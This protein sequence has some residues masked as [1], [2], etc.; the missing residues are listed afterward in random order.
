MN[1]A[2]KL[3]I[4][5]T[6]I[7][8]ILTG[9]GW[10][11]SAPVTSL[12]ESGEINMENNLGI[13]D[14]TANDIVSQMKVGWNLGN[15]MDV[16]ESTYLKTMKPEKW[17][18]GWG[19]PVTTEALMQK[20]I[21]SGFNVIR[22]PVSWND[23]IFVG[24]GYKIEEGWMD[25]IQEI[26]DY[27]Y[28]QDAYV[29]L[30]THHESWYYP[31]YDNKEH[32]SEMMEAIWNQIAERFQDYGEKLIFEGMNEPRKI[33]TDMEWN[34]GDQEGWDMVNHFN[35]VFIETIRNA[36][37]NNPDRILMIPGY[38]ANC[39][40]AIEHIEVPEDTKIIVSV[41]AYEPYDFAL[42]TKGRNTWNRDT[43]NIDNLLK[44]IDEKFISK[45]IPVIIGEFGAMY[46][47][48]EGNEEDRAAWAN[49]YV[50][51]A[52]ELGIPCVWWDNGAFEGDGELFGLINRETCEWKYPL[53]IKGLMEGTGQT[54]DMSLLEQN[55]PDE[56]G[57]FKELISYEDGIANVGNLYRLKSAMQKAQAG[58]D[59]TVAFIG[60][61]ITQGSLSSKPTTCYAYLVYEW[62]Q[63]KF[64]D[65][66]I[67]YVNAGIGGTTS[68]FGV[69]RVESD[70]LGFEP[71]VTFVEFSV[72]DENNAFY[73][74]T[75]EG[76][77]RKI[78]GSDTD[79]AVMLLHNVMY[80]NGGNAQ[81]QHEQ[82][83][84]HYELPCLS[85]KTSVYSK[86][87][88]GTIKNREITPDDLHPNDKG[89]DL[90]AGLVISF[91]EEV[92]TDLESEET[93]VSW[94]KDGLPEALTVNAYENSIR[95]QNGN[96]SPVMNGFVA[97]TQEQKHIT[98][99]FRNGWTAEKVGDSIEFEVE[100]TGIAVQY[101]KS[102]KQP[103]CIAK[104]V[105]DGDEENAIILDGN[106]KETW[107]DCLYLQTLLQHGEDKVHHVKI[108]IVE[109]AE[110]GYVP[111]YLVSVIGSR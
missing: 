92:A 37:G 71:D 61:S 2:G 28:N 52:K 17:E 79:P 15:T 84:K 8:F 42:N 74:E 60:G 3:T 22:I 19:N 23:H 4:C 86:V 111:F 63:N 51:A 82:I 90:L 56:K 69:A 33:G 78:Y 5:I 109:P 24:E 87:S 35:S 13:K 95:Y 43:T 9:C 31:Y 96:T 53:I 11:L 103:A 6:L 45:G 81:G 34:G 93:P 38:A 108:T 46:K 27:A 40:K 58:E 105:I 54:I 57:D 59:I 55:T 67:T 30:N 29:I 65:S 36:G 10:N 97:D 62:W 7:V 106:F 73:K 89:H 98:E 75:Y 16:I 49:Y 70:V 21:D 39:W 66:E 101:R 85:M 44:S 80:H 72:N 32:G 1:R 83:G 41:H 68:Q 18:T 26:V 47:E 94:E 99:I 76:L 88:D 48:V 50:S 25:R 91:L 110:E 64:P 12:E 20:V 107:G 14:M 77:V 104:A 102:V 100:G